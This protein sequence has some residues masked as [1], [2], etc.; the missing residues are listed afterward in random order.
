MKKYLYG[1]TALAAVALAAGPAL[2]EAEPPPLELGGY[3]TGW[4]MY[5]DP[6]GAANGSPKVGA[7]SP[8]PM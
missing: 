7:L 4:F 1:T 3:S 5:A 6:D 2:A 8:I